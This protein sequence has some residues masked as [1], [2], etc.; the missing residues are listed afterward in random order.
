MKDERRLMRPSRANDRGLEH[1]MMGKMACVGMAAWQ[2][3]HPDQDLPRLGVE[4]QSASTRRAEH[5]F[6]RYRSIARYDAKGD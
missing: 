5:V 4:H 1:Y 6:T 3:C 2:A